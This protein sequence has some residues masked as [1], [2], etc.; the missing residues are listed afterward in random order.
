MSPHLSIL[1]LDTPGNVLNEI[2]AE[3]EGGR[4]WRAT[5]EALMPRIK[6]DFNRLPQAM[7]TS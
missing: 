7:T 1:T 6:E 3:V 5:V 2:I 4:P